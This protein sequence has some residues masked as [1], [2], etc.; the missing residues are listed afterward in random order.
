MFLNT[1]FLKSA[2]FLMFFMQSITAI[3]QHAT[4]QTEEIQE[5]DELLNIYYGQFQNLSMLPGTL[6][7]DLFLQSYVYEKARKCAAYL[8]EDKIEL[9][10][11]ECAEEY[12]ESNGYGVEISRTCVRWRTVKT[13]LYT[14]PELHSAMKSNKGAS[15]NNTAKTMVEM[16]NGA[17][18]FQYARNTVRTSKTIKSDIALL[19]MNNDCDGKGLKV[20]ETNLL[21]LTYGRKGVTTHYVPS[22]TTDIRAVDYGNQ[23]Y[24]ALAEDLIYDQSKGWLLN[25]YIA[26]SATNVTISNKDQEG[27][28]EII[29]AN[30]SYTGIGGKLNG[31]VKITF[32]K[33]LPYCLYFHDNPRACNP[34]AKHIIKKLKKNQYAK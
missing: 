1:R 19:F 34:A 13:G 28:P 4:L 18:P 20:F 25:R 31:W 27:K 30:Y 6:S 2:V 3:A 7:F 24:R 16:L 21:N 5:K 8:P 15:Q 22:K 23:D 17:D 33:G 26:N 9:T 32:N 29:T 11:E 12:V 10:Y 14:T